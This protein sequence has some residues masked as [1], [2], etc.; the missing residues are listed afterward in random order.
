M[1]EVA[2]LVFASDGAGRCLYFEAIDLHTL[3]TLRCERV[4][5]I[6]FDAGT[7][8]WEVMPADSGTVLFRSP[9]RQQC[10]DWEREHFS[11][12]V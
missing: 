12:A 2:S 4:S 6:E 8:Q 3:G 7:Q 1:Q 5:R 9:S 10:L 11:F